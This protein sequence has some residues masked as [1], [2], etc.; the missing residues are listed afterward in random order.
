MPG[1]REGLRPEMSVFKS[2]TYVYLNIFGLIFQP[3][4]YTHW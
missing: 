2:L 1:A 3:A 4:M